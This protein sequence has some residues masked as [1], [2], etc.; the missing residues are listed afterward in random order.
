[1]GSRFND[2]C[3]STNADAADAFFLEQGPFFTSG[4]T[5][6]VGWFEKNV[7]NVWQIKRQSIASNGTITTLTTS[8][9]TVPTFP[10]CTPLD[11][12]NDGLTL[13]WGI[14]AAMVAAYAIRFLANGLQR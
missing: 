4:A 8:N 11:S 13:G 10:T 6:Y 3:Y 7:S 9:A 2:K 1:M 5:S 12:M 14:A